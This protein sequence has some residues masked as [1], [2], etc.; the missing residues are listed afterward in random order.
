MGSHHPR[1]LEPRQ[2]LLLHCW[3]LPSAPNQEPRQDFLSQ[4][5]LIPALP[6]RWSHHPRCLEPR[7]VL[8]LHCW[9][10]S[11][12]PHQEPRQE[13]RTLTSLTSLT[14]STSLTST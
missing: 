7:Q 8:L 2:V 1:C 10:L 6:H 14:S 5:P 11:L 9:V 3:V 4:R 13:R 12:A